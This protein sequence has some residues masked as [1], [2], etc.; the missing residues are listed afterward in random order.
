[1]SFFDDPDFAF[2]KGEKE[3]VDLPN[4][5]QVVLF[6]KKVLEDSEISGFI[7]IKIPKSMKAGSFF[8]RLETT[9]EISIDKTEND[10]KLEG[11]LKQ[12]AKKINKEQVATTDYAKRGDY[13]TKGQNNK[14]SMVCP[15]TPFSNRP[16]KEDFLILRGEDEVVEPITT[17]TTRMIWD[18]EVFAT[19]NEISRFTVLILP[20]RCKLRGKLR[21]SCDLKIDNIT[22]YPLNKKKVA[23]IKK[24]NIDKSGMDINLLGKNQDQI[25]SVATRPQNG[26]KFS[27]NHYLKLNHRLICY[28]AAKSEIHNFHQMHHGMKEEEIVKIRYDTLKK[29]DYFFTHSR[30]FYVIPNFRSMDYKK[31]IHKGHANIEIDSS[32]FFCC[33]KT[34]TLPVNFCLDAINI[35]SNDSSLN[36]VMTFDR[37]MVQDCFYLDVVIY[38]RL[39]YK[40]DEHH[41]HISENVCMLE[42]FNLDTRLPSKSREKLVE[43]VQKLDLTPIKGKYQTVDSFHCNYKYFIRFYLSSLPFR[44]GQLLSEIELY[45]WKIENDFAVLDSEWIDE[46][47]K[48]LETKLSPYKSSVMLPYVCLEFNPEPNSTGLLFPEDNYPVEEQPEP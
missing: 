17:A 45:F 32:Y 38:S 44:L 23:N 28:F 7:S 46:N 14:T 30:E 4:Q 47:F 34:L 35:R 3:T 40:E 42:S 12:L 19:D 6:A 31:L 48:K 36:F 1:M 33:T 37:V 21:R 20:F 9:E 8:L 18:I 11:K 25:I 16:L 43:Y 39:D 27:K 41:N 22:Y 13:R 29:S 15:V 5:M 2:A 10:D 26:D 24:V